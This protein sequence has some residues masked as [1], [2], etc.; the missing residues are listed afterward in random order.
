[1][2][3]CLDKRHSHSL[4]YL[5]D[6]LT[7]KLSTLQEISK[8]SQRLNKQHNQHKSQQEVSIL[9][10]KNLF[11]WFFVEFIFSTQVKPGLYLSIAAVDTLVE[12]KAHNDCQYC[13]GGANITFALQ[14]RISRKKNTRAVA[15]TLERKKKKLPI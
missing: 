14:K 8:A 3:E 13:R 1:M 2:S 12:R 11:L 6:T 9:C 7:L 5:E 4:E 15:H 10:D